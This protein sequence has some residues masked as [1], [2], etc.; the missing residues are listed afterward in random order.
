[1]GKVAERRF[2]L[3]DLR[4]SQQPVHGQVAVLT[5]ALQI[6]FGQPFTEFRPDPPDR[7]G[8]RAVE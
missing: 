8:I 2:A 6:R 5:E 3:V 4:G 1:M 7:R